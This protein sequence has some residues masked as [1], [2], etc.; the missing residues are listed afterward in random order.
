MGRSSFTYTARR[1]IEVIR[2]NVSDSEEKE[3]VYRNII[4]VFEEYDYDNIN[5]CTEID[6][7]FDAL[8]TPEVIIPEDE[9]PEDI[10][11]DD[12]EDDTWDEDD[13]L[14]EEDFEDDY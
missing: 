2:D 13:D 3:N 5:E 12:D 11:E 6:P 7:I 4:E 10:S 8:I 1:I 9:E 14:D